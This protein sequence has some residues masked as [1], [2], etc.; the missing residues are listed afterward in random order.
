MFGYVTKQNCRYWREKTHEKRTDVVCIVN[1]LQ[2]CVRNVTNEDYRTI[3]FWRMWSSIS[4]LPRRSRTVCLYAVEFFCTRTK[5]SRYRERNRFRRDEATARAV[6]A[7][8]LVP[9]EM[10]PRG[11]IPWLARS[12]DSTLCT[13]CFPTGLCEI[14]KISSKEP[15]NVLRKRFT[16]RFAARPGKLLKKSC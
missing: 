9:R 1:V 15:S 8:M 10:F 16:R 12:P 2:C 6:R 3:L 11:V 13:R 5:R 14:S 4:R 7:S